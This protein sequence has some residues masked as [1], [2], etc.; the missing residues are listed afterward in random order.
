[1]LVPEPLDVVRLVVVPAAPPP[2]GV[3]VVPIGVACEL[4]WPAPTAGFVT[5]A[6]GG[7]PWASA[8]PKT[9]ASAVAIAPLVNFVL[10]VEAPSLDGNR[11]A[12][13]TGWSPR[14]G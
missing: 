6:L 4:C 12:E 9:A 10:I 14:L 7:L 2:A 3:P 1:M 13:I 8:T 5:L 11:P